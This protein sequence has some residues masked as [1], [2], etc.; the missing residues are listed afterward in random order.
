MT[1]AG[2]VGVPTRP[3]VRPERGRRG[4]GC[5]RVRARGDAPDPA[6]DPGARRAH[7]P[8]DAAPVGDRR[9][10]QAPG[11]ARRRARA[12]RRHRARRGGRLRQRRRRRAGRRAGRRP[13]RRSRDRVRGTRPPPVR[14]ARVLRRDRP[15]GAPAPGGQTERRLAECAKLG[16]ATV[17]APAGTSRRGKLRVAEAETLRDAMHRARA[18]PGRQDAEIDGSDRR[19]APRARA[20]R[21]RRAAVAPGPSSARGSTTSSARTRAR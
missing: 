10:P 2:L 18:G 8:R 5:G 6:R 13:R 11:D 20:A 12:A 21:G 15:D 9:R 3:S 7:R 17:V 19:P 14:A 1:G 16:V 4:R